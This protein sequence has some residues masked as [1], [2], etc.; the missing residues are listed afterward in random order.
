MHRWL[1]AML[2]V[3]VL[4]G[5][6]GSSSEPSITTSAPTGSPSSST[7]VPPPGASAAVT[8]LPPGTWSSIDGWTFSFDRGHWSGPG[9][10]Q[11]RASLRHDIGSGDVSLQLY[12]SDA[13]SATAC[14][15]DYVAFFA[16][17]NPGRS[18][19]P[20]DSGLL[21]EATIWTLYRT[22]DSEGENDDKFVACRQL[23][24]E[25]VIEVFGD[26]SIYDPLTDE[27]DVWSQE[28][29]PIL[30]VVAAIATKDARATPR[31]TAR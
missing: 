5:C 13:S 29:M 3:V 24:P 16:E 4:A 1:A 25:L 20:L 27:H 12:R 22:E 8:S 21:D 23:G 31:T 14:V 6:D 11:H 30:S 19:E 28:L 2:L 9:T 26:V 7:T 10:D 15:A 18:A 17:R